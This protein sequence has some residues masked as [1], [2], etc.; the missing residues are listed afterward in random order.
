[1]GEEKLLLLG[2]GF[3]REQA[4]VDRVDLCLGS[5]CV[6]EIAIDDRLRMGHLGEGGAVEQGQRLRYGSVR[7]GVLDGVSIG[8]AEFP[9]LL[10]T[11]STVTVGTMCTPLMC[12]GGNLSRANCR[13][14]LWMNG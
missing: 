10:T 4:E 5:L 8:L 2:G 11:N 9:A 6:A 13:S 1:M 7:I 14:I 3:S 12:L